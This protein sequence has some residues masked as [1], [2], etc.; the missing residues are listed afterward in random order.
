MFREIPHFFRGNGGLIA[1]GLW[2]PT[3]SGGACAAWWMELVPVDCHKWVCLKVMLSLFSDEPKCWCLHG[4][5]GHLP[6]CD[7]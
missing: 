3:N 4:E 2:T 6:D 1:S 7:P 5:N